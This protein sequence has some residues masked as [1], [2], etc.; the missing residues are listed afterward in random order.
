[1]KK[2]PKDFYWGG[3]TSA[4][5][6][7][8][9]YDVNGRGLSKIDYLTAGSKKRPRYLTYI[10][11][12]GKLGKIPQF[13]DLPKN[14]R[15]KLLE[16]TYYPNH[17]A[18]DFYHTY[19][20]DIKLFAE[21]GFTIFRMSI[22]MSRIFPK[23]DETEPCQKG[24]QFY[25]D[26]FDELKKY[27][28]EPLVTISHYDTPI[29]LENKYHNWLDRGIINHFI[30]YAN[31]L[32]QEYKEKVTYWLTFNELNNL[33]LYPDLLP[34]QMVTEKMINETY[35][36]LHHYFLASAKMVSLAHDINP[37]Y[38]V[39]AML[40]GSMTYPLTC[41]PKDI[42]KNQE[43]YQKKNYYCGDVMMKGA[44]PYFAQSLW[45]KTGAK[46][47]ISQEDEEILKKGTVDFCSLSYYSSSCVTRHKE[48]EKSSGNFSLGSKNPYLEYSEW[49]WSSDPEGLRI[50]LNDLYSRYAVPLMLVENGLG[51]EDKLINGKIH[52]D[53]RIDYIRQHI[54]AMSEAIEDGV[55]LIGYTSWG[56][57]DL[58]SASTGEMNKRYGFIYVDLDNEGNGTRRRYKK[59]SF[60]WYKRVIETNGEEL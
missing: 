20:G 30:K 37:D 32:F 26:I 55:D 2:F 41:D 54:E 6:I 16:D 28:I 42:Q 34:P 15:E 39:G 14:G 50:Y 23:G 45:K 36:K 35:I 58:I 4:S 13:F 1:M 5:Q 7:E 8:G 25:H 59:D 46:I 27:H 12:G 38:K 18:I 31:V 19:K 56:C 24:L 33:L 49:G 29:Y 51:A 9:A 3:A 53:Y 60:D 57:I 22:S 47:I 10:D 44:Y 43:D 11:E 48:S 52:D 17:K 40:C 21:M